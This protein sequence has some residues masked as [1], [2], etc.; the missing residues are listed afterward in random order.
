M[1]KEIRARGPVAA[2]IACPL[3]FS[4]YKSGIFSDDHIKEFL[5]IQDS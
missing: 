1:M 4:Y 3:G 2:D 5:K